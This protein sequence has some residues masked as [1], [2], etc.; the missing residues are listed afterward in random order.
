MTAD[1]PEPPALRDHPH[2]SLYT[3]NPAKA[4]FFFVPSF[5]ACYLFDCWV[6]AGWKK[7]ERCNVDEGYIQPIMRHVREAYPYWNASGGSDH[8]LT[9]PMDYVDGYYTE[10][11]RLAMNSSTY[12]VTV[13][14]ARPAPYGQYFR[15]YRDVVIPSATHLINSYHVNPRD[16][17]DEAGDP[18]PEPRGAADPKRRLADANLPYPEV[19]Q[20][21]P[22]DV[23]VWTSVERFLS[24]LLHGRPKP[25]AR[26]TLAIFRGGW[27]EAT[28]GEAYALGIR[29]LFFPSDGD[30][31]TPPFSS[32]KHHGFS[33][34]PNFDIALW[35]ENDD[36][37][38]RL[39]R[40]K[41]GLAPPGYTLDTTRLYEYL[42]FGVVPVFI[43][44]GPT[45]GQVLPFERDVDWHGMSISIPRERAHQVPSILRAISDDEYERKRR[46][47]W[48]EGRRT[49]LEGRE[50]NVWKLIA[51]QLC[52]LKRLGV[53]AGPEIANN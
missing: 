12:L 32:T 17:V 49:I 6:K 5:P 13:G 41:F 37:A 44:T 27:G 31:S 36:Y 47:V 33:S 39:S 15:S 52:R 45:A 22:A 1:S 40:S 30:P 51:R 23:T 9:H 11:T 4:D 46:K 21:S 25:A 35:S 28:D 42:A 10:E 26:T 43:G 20:P 2:D 16:F 14:D 3:E 8:L 18:L 29:S 7:T 48:D 53:A 24:R 50:G 38:R 34:L 19:F